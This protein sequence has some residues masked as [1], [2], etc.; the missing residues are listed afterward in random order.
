MLSDVS[1][2]AYLWTVD[3]TQKGHV[4]SFCY[5]IFISTILLRVLLDPPSYSCTAK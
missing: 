1:F 5:D 3:D 2:Y 4:L